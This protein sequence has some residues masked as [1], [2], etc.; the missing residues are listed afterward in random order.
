MFN[1]WQDFERLK[2][3][4]IFVSRQVPSLWN[5]RNHHCATSGMNSFFWSVG[6][7]QSQKLECRMLQILHI[8]QICVANFVVTSSSRVG[9]QIGSKTSS[10]FAEACFGFIIEQSSKVWFLFLN[11]TCSFPI[12]YDAATV[13]ADK[14][15]S[16]FCI[17][18]ACKHVHD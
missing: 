7:Y 1:G 8:N 11:Q 10:A 3:I 16:D 14:K 6:S 9:C 5:S 15:K 12:D 18:Y 4:W 13:F 2:S 17:L